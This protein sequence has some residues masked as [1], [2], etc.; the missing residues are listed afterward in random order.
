[1]QTQ[2]VERHRCARLCHTSL[3]RARPFTQPRGEFYGFGQTHLYQISLQQTLFPH[4][5]QAVMARTTL[6]SVQ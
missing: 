3:F 5:A 6:R 2:R 1:M 4:A